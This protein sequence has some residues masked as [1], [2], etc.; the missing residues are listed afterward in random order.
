M[1]AI[2]STMTSNGTTTTGEEGVGVGG[3]RVE[4]ERVL[5]RPSSRY[6][7]SCSVARVYRGGDMKGGGGGETVA[8]NTHFK[9]ASTVA[10]YGRVR[11]TPITAVA[12]VMAIVQRL[13]NLGP[14]SAPPMMAPVRPSQQSTVNTLL[15]P[16]GRKGR[17]HH[18]APCLSPSLHFS[19]EQEKA[20]RWPAA[21][22]FSVCAPFFRDFFASFPRLH[23]T[24][25]INSLSTV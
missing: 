14:L 15:H 21:D 12:T 9:Y 19:L 11:V 18:R 16:S 10:K 23:H 6:F 13:R 25:R 17:P 4:G 3:E 24:K 22:S 2:D 7:F 1:V 5:G 8:K 20:N